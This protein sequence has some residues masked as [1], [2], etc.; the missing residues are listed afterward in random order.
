M[1][2]SNP[3][4]PH[5]LPLVVDPLNACA[6]PLSLSQAQAIYRSAIDPTARDDEGADWWAKVAEE[7]RLVRAAASVKTAASVIQWWHH[8]WASV[9][10]SASAAARRIRQ[11]PLA[12]LKAS[13]TK[14][15]Q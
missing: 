5:A 2:F 10:D 3:P 4:E 13:I 11:V 7:M 14:T 9:G 15:P 6:H 12:G 1:S 8:D